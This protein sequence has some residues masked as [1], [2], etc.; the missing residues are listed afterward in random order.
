MPVFAGLH[1]RRLVELARKDRLAPLYIF[2]GEPAEARDKAGRILSVQEE[3]GALIE[4]VDLA[5]TPPDTLPA[6]LSSGGLFGPRRL[7]LAASGEVLSERPELAPEI[8]RAL[9]PGGVHLLLLAREFPEDHE[10]YRFAEEKGAVVPLALQKGRARFLNELAER[11]SAE[12]KSMERTVA[13]YFLSLVGEDYAHFRNELEKV[14]LHAGERETIRREDVEAVVV[15]AEEAALFLLGDTLLEKGPEAARGLLRRL[16]DHGEA[17]PRIEAAL[18]TYFKR[19]WLLAHLVSR[20]PE[21]LRERSFE[22]FRRTLENLLKEV[23][24]DKPPALLSRVHPYALFRLKRHLDNLSEERISEIFEA[25]YELDA[26]LKRDFQAPERAFYSF[27]LRVYR[28]RG[29]APLKEGSADRPAFAGA[30]PG[31]G[32]GF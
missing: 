9:S 4:R 18:F 6:L 28:L 20:R 11:L 21:L 2:V 10:L 22:N 8:L 15:P 32:R 3:R 14:I 13:E 23:W 24:P 31:S 19:L 1:F 26:A 17:P 5:E 16:L 25:L 30:L 29:R 7:V 27:F 12:G